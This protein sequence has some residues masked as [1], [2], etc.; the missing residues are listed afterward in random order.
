MNKVWSD[1][2]NCTKIWKLCFLSKKDENKQKEALLK[3]LQNISKEM[4]HLRMGEWSTKKKQRSFLCAVIT[5]KG[6][7]IL[8]LT[9]QWLQTSFDN[10][11]DNLKLK[12]QQKNLSRVQTNFRCKFKL[13]FLSNT[14]GW[15]NIV[16]L[17]DCLTRA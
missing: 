6:L 1:V 17:Y 14:I 8:I 16:S 4:R 12:W 13:R 7:F 11:W 10:N 5:T 15:L 9:A 3:K 2:W